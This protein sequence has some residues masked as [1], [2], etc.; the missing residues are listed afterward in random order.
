MTDTLEHIA[1]R[2]AGNA[3]FEEALRLALRER[4]LKPDWPHEIDEAVEQIGNT[5]DRAAVLVDQLYGG[6]R[7]VE[8]ADVREAA[9]KIIVTTLRAILETP[10]G[11]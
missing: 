4:V 8:R 11:K 5:V 9:I 6:R 7:G 10:L 2:G 3:V 1:Y